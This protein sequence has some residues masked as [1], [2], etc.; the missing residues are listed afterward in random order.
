MKDFRGL[1]SYGQTYKENC[2]N[3]EIK[4]SRKLC[5][6]AFN[7]LLFGKKIEEIKKTYG[8]RIVSCFNERELLKYAPG[9][10]NNNTK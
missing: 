10:L 3:R 6:E 8:D 9:H 1:P 5:Q 4:Y 2:L 7:D